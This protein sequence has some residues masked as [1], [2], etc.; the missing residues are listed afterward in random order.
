[1][2][3]VAVQTVVGLVD[4]AVTLPCEA[5]RPDP[6]DKLELV[7]W[8]RLGSKLPVLHLSP[9]ALVL[10]SLRQLDRGVYVCRADFIQSP[11]RVGVTNLTLIGRPP[12]KLLWYWRGHLLDNTFENGPAGAVRNTLT[13][14]HLARTDLRSELSCA[15]SNSN[16][17]EPRTTTLRLQLLLPPLDVSLSQLPDHLRAKVTYRVTCTARGSRPAARIRWLRGAYSPIVS[18]IRELP[19]AD[20]NITV[21]ELT[22][23]ADV[24]EDSL[25]LT[26]LAENA[27]LPQ[28]AAISATR[29][30]P[31]HYPPQILLQIGRT[32]VASDIKE[33]NDVYFDCQVR[34]NPPVTELS[35]YHQGKQLVSDRRSNVM[36]ID[37]SLVLPNVS[38]HQ[39]GSYTCGASNAEGHNQSEPLLL[40]VMYLPRCQ[41]EQQTVFFLP[42]RSFELR[43]QLQARPTQVRFKWDVN[44][45]ATEYRRAPLTRFSTSGSSSSVQHRLDSEESAEVRCW[46]SNAIGLQ[47]TPCIFHLEPAG[48]PEPVQGCTVSNST[49]TSFDVRCK[50]G[51]DGGLPQTF[52]LEVRDVN[53]QQVI[54]SVSQKKAEFH[55]RGLS[56]GAN[57]SVTVFASSARGRGQPHVLQ[58]GTVTMIPDRIAYSRSAA[59]GPV[60][61]VLGGLV[62][63][64]LLLAAAV[65]VSLR[66]RL[67]RRGPLK[68]AEQEAPE[69]T[70]SGRDQPSPDLLPTGSGARSL[71]GFSDCS[72]VSSPHQMTANYKSR[73]KR[74]DEDMFES[75]DHVIPNPLDVYGHRSVDPVRTVGSLGRDPARSRSAHMPTS[76]AYRTF[77]DCGRLTVQDRDHSAV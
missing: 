2:N 63:L 45:T 57:F 22:L 52:V 17:T 42:G 11:S 41:I 39:A 49:I 53:T 4:G 9:P 46:G 43:C 48:V 74:T 35:W 65:I 30:L 15:A 50:P 72:V 32:L 37:R 47:R 24:G 71:S 54:H 61:A 36:I 31:V 18:G 7:L 56:P 77:S 3:S 28:R 16:L 59:A 40:Q 62:L 68:T 29:S 27:Q 1:M 19:S 67:P 73:L 6:D 13:L 66:R 33:G 51:N 58:V 55:V 14:H 75:A 8:Y 23:T 20:P 60:A 10:S 69:V 64:L 38:R 44:S 21:S 34:A 5:S 25:E 76:A 12:P 70:G 26:C